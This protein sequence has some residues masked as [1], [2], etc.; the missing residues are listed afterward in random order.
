[1][2]EKVVYPRDVNISELG[3]EPTQFEFPS[4]IYCADQTEYCIVILADTQG[5]RAHI[6]RMGQE[7]MDGSGIISAQ[8]HA[9]VFFKS[10]NAS[11]WTADQMEDL[12]FR[13]HRAV[14]DTTARGEVIS[15]KHRI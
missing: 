13:V 10:Q 3:T 5:Y 7:A 4:P 1:M 14:F 2:G 11:T 15:R 8:P 12:K 9:G 6:S